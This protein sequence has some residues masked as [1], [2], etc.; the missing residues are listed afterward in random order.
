MLKNC[1]GGGAR[2]TS[3]SGSGRVL[4][5]RNGGKG[6][7]VESACD[8]DRDGRVEAPGGVGRGRETEPTGSGGNVSGLGVDKLIGCLPPSP[9]PPNP[10]TQFGVKNETETLKLWQVKGFVGTITTLK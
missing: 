8:S 7:G 4:L 5:P 3:S 6:G 2:D 1:S 10:P 9:P